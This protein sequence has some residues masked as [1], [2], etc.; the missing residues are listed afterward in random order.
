[1]PPGGEEGRAR[2]ELGSR[3]GGKPLLWGLAQL[4]GKRAGHLSPR[5]LLEGRVES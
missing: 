2:W 3:G 5:L 4:F 1:M